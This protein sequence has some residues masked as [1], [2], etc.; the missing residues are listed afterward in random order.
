MLHLETGF[1]AEGG[2]LFDGERVLVEVL[3]STGLAEVD[4]DVATALHFQTQR[5]DDH[6]AFVVRI[7]EVVT[8]S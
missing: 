3:H 1:H 2:A 5:E 7:A 8:G 6:A 4:D